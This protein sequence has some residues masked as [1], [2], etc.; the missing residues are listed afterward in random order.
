MKKI[1]YIFARFL[2]ASFL[3]FVMV[4]NKQNKS[5]GIQTDTNYIS[6]KPKIRYEDIKNGTVLYGTIVLKQ[7]KNGL[8]TVASFGGNTINEKKKNEIF[9]ILK[10]INKTKELK[11]YELKKAI[12]VLTG[13]AP[14]FTV[15]GN[16]Y[17]LKVYKTKDGIY[18][19]LMNNLQ[20][21]KQIKIFYLGEYNG[22]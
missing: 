6:Y 3:F 17:Y 19:V 20:D 22:K 12:K 9:S 5:T 16:S 4:A 11:K 7:D 10:K 18:Y 13:K 1:E 21:K 8:R 2:I 14:Y 15:S